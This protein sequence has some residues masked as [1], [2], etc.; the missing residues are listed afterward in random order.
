MRLLSLHPSVQLQNCIP[1]EI[2]FQFSL[3]EIRMEGMLNSSDTINW[4]GALRKRISGMSGQEISLIIIVTGPEW[5]W[6]LYH[7]L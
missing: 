6:K 7:N 5:T 1:D 3:N 4:E 2:Q